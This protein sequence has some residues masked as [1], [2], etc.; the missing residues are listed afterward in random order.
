MNKRQI[1][2]LSDIFFQLDNT[3]GEPGA[4]IIHGVYSGDHKNADKIL[5]QI[6]AIVDGVEAHPD[7]ATMFFYQQSGGAINHVAEGATAFSNRNAV[8]TPTVIV[9]W[10]DGTDPEPHVRYI[11][12]YWQT[13]ERF[14]DGFY[15]NLGDFE[16]QASMNSNYRGNHAR[17]VNLKN[18]YD[19]GNL[20]RLNANIQPTIGL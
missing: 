11:R 14:T 1:L 3:G 10:N 16:S 9:S 13:I 6:D 12:S 2:L 8:N 15:T 4:L 17:L 7:R 19:P 5:A 18:R 20:F